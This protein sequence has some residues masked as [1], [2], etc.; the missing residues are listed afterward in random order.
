MNDCG[1]SFNFKANHGSNNRTKQQL[2]LG[3]NVE[4]SSFKSENFL[5]WKTGRLTYRYESLDI[6]FAELG[7]CYNTRFVVK[8]R[9]IFRNRLTTSFEGQQMQDILNELAVLYDLQF[10]SQGDTIYVRRKHQ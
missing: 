5:Y 7:N 2:S 9:E 3:T 10:T 1:K 8:D 4:Q 6:V